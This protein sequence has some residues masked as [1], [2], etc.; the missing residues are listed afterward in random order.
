M[1]KYIL[2]IDDNFHY[3]DEG[4]RSSHSDYER[5][6][7]AIRAAKRMVD[8]SLRDLYRIGMTPQELLACYKAFGEEPWITGSDFSAWDYAEQQCW[9][10]IVG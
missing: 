8:E 9:E 1:S 5:E 3:M 7:D 6:D 10:K 2:Y 4:P